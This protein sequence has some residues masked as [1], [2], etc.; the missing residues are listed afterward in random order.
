LFSYLV[1]GASVSC[2]AV[3]SNDHKIV[4]ELGKQLATIAKADGFPPMAMMYHKREGKMS[5]SFRSVDDYD[6]TMF[7][8]NYGGRGHKQASGCSIDLAE[9]EKFKIQ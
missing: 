7:S 8:K 2:Y 5:V 9:F 3:E 4:S 1:Q 6:T